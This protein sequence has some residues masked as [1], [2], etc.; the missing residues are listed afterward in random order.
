MAAEKVLII[1]DEEK[2]RELLKRAIDKEGYSTLVASDG[3]E[4]L[5]VFR[6]EKPDIVITDVK[7]PN[8]DGLEVLHTVK[9]I[10]PSTEVILVTAHGEYDTAILALRQGTLDYIKKPVDLDQLIFS[11]GRA[12]EK[13]TTRKKVG[14]KPVILILEDDGNTRNQLVR[15]F[16]KEEYVV[17]NG[18]DGE[19]GIQI[20]SQNKIDIVLT[21]IKMPR[22]N[23]LEVL[24]EVKRLSQSCE[25]IMLTGYGDEDTA[26]QAMRDGANNYIRKPIDL[27]QLIIA[28]QKAVEKLQLQ[29]AYLY[30]VRELELA[31]EIIAK[32]TE[33]QELVIEMRDSSQI[34]VRDFAL[35]LINTIPLPFILTDRDMNVDFVNNHFVRLYGYKPER[36]DEDLLKKSGLEHIG[37]EGIREGV[38]KLYQKGETGI[39]TLGVPKQVVMAKVSLIN[40]EG[41]REK[42]LIITGGGK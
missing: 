19:A 5:Q 29:R 28:V 30:K 12:S 20:F 18:A 13:I 40:N 35:N 34:S 37:V 6:R 9:N 22:K 36:I 31:Q 38:S 4:G 10:S 2:T 14:I 21:D 24:H 42:V 7:M 41:K 27:D 15:V 33:Q 3:L 11:L 26:V 17:F 39:I 25:V 8:V 23:G 1:E 16:E 32:I